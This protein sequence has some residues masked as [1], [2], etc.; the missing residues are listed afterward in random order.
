M[1]KRVGIYKGVGHWGHLRILPTTGFR[2]LGALSHHYTGVAMMVAPFSVL[3]TYSLIPILVEVAHSSCIWPDVA[4]EKPV[5]SRGKVT[6][7]R[8]PSQLW[9]QRVAVMTGSMKQGVVLT[10]G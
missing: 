2:G 4:D 3:C 5:V 8:W 9:A 1:L 7:P 6:C 10:S